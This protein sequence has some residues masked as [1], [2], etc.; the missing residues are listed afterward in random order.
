MADENIERLAFNRGVISSKGLARID[1]ERM[2]MSADIQRN[3]IPRVLG[4]MMIRPGFEFIL[5]TLNNKKSRH[6]PFVFSV[7]ETAQLAFSDDRMKII[8]D[9]A[10]IER[11]VV[12]ATVTNPDFDA[13]VTSWT[14]NDDLG[15]TSSW[16]NDAF[17]GGVLS[18]VGDGENAAIR[19]QQVTVTE[20]GTEHA[21]EIEVVIGTATLRVGSTDGDDDYIVESKL[22]KGIHNL[23][24]T[25]TGNFWIQFSSTT[26]HQVW[27]TS[28]DM[29]A[30]GDVSFISPWGE[31]NL[32]FLRFDQSGDVIYISCDGIRNM[33]VERRGDGR[34][35]SLVNYFPL[36]GPFRIQN[37]SA[38]T[39]STT[40][41]VGQITLTAS[42]PIFKTTH[43]DNNSLFRL[44][45]SGQ[46]V[47]NT[48]SAQN[49]FTDPI[50]V[51]GGEEARVFTLK[52][53]NRTDSTITLQFAFASDGP[54]NDLAPQYTADQVT[55]YDD[56]QDGQIIYYRIGI[57]T[58]DYGTDTVICTLTYTGGS[59]QGVVRV[60]S[61]IDSTSVA[62]SVIKN[63]GSTDPTSDW[64]EGEW[65]AY[66][67]YPTSVGLHE[68]RLWWA[69]NDKVFG[70]ISDFYESFDDNF[71]GDGGPISRSIGFGPIKIIHWMVSMGRLLFGTSTNSANIAAAK[72]DGNDPLGARSNSFDEPLTPTNFNVK[73]V[74]TK[75]IFVDRSGQRLYE[76]T[77]N[78]DEQDYKALDLSVFTPDF[79][80]SGITQIA[81]QMK[82]DVRIHCV[83]EDGTVGILIFDRLENVIC[84]MD[85]DSS[86]AGGLIEDVSVL[87]GTEEDQ[88][89]YTIKRTIN[90]LTQRHLCKW[91]MESE[92][93][94]GQLNKMADSFVTYT[95]AAT[96]TPFT[97]ELLH[98]RGET[99]V[100]WAD[101]IDVGT[102]VVTA[103]GALT[104]ALATAASNV[105]VGL[106]YTAQFKSTKLSQLGG[107]GLLERKKVNRIG[108]LAENMH[109]QGLQ[110][111]PDFSN[112][113]DL[114]KVSRGQ[115]Q[116]VSQIYA[117]YHEDDFAFGGTWNED[118]RICLQ[119][120]AP[121]PCTILAAIAEMQ[122]VESTSPRRGK[123]RS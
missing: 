66:R 21:L 56:G 1:L 32:P 57:K 2:G 87:P 97:T 33:K 50:R 7:D 27:I 88:V 20:T 85:V 37:T 117:E 98:L 47:T 68:G 58:G 93:I 16:V 60:N 105:V 96:T 17:Y 116:S 118:A 83:R 15:A 64:W 22:G 120:A 4:S 74:S 78:M 122:S 102:D 69:G 61:F 10:F 94:G 19:T 121:R 91:A 31:E 110:Y 109:Y 84:W 104:T 52:I 8:I 111:G 75:S 35:W 99:V 81:V 114:P 49:V 6:I 44:S 107:I 29:S 62:A 51:V 40:D 13:G 90:G 119:A 48:I 92:A 108:F 55:A 63:L 115:E 9:D 123:R 38:T 86:G 73:S 25:P 11:P 70:S 95:G 26:E 71:E 28:C 65:S 36:D 42:K 18:L 112:L 89:Y 100:I 103:A 79:N 45:S 46:N 5:N 72:I 106:S 67:G 113:S 101:G 82:P 34:S 3:W 59:I 54:W 76:M 41:I 77:Y 12:S 53:E 43:A 24:F 14:D 23:S 80:V 30:S 39:L